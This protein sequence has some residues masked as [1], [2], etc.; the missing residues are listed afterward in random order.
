[1]LYLQFIL[2][3]SPAHRFSQADT[4]TFF[5]IASAE[6]IYI[7]EFKQDVPYDSSQAENTS[8][9]GHMMP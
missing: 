9:F 5:N 1:M 6:K 4:S 3:L 7:I 2:K 8:S